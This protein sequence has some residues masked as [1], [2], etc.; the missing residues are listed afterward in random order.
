MRALV[1]LLSVLLLSACASTQAAN[2]AA[3]EPPMREQFAKSLHA[4]FADAEVALTRFDNA[5][6]L[7][8]L[9]EVEVATKDWKKTSPAE[10]VALGWLAEKAREIRF[11]AT[12]FGEENQPD[13]LKELF[14]ADSDRQFER[15]VGDGTT[16][17]SPACYQ[18]YAISGRN[19]EA[20]RGYGRVLALLDGRQ[21]DVRRFRLMVL[22]ASTLAGMNQIE[23]ADAEHHRLTLLLGEM[24]LARVQDLREFASY[25]ILPALML[26]RR[27][28]Y[29]EASKLMS[30]WF[31][32]VPEHLAKPRQDKTG[33]ALKELAET[34]AAEKERWSKE[35]ADLPRVE[36][37]TDKGKMVLT[38]FE[39]DC[40]NTVAS[41]ITLVEKGFYDGTLFHRVVPHFVVQGG[42]PDG[43]GSGGPGYAIKREATRLHF[44]GSIGMA[45]NADPDSAGS[46]FYFC[47]NAATTF[48]LNA[49]YCVFGRVSEGLDVM[50]QLRLGSRIIKARVLSKRA[51]E[52]KIER[53]PEKE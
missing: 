37:E 31:K 44:R 41:F 51:H 26:A 10:N 9:N 40:P 4:R 22:H 8:I 50:D 52:Y 5:G 45:R 1:L 23:Q 16:L 19:E 18:L 15:F 29:A 33:K 24:G 6:A 14:A 35:P 47:L 36:I 34:W 28:D 27:E 20:E 13:K 49:G 43:T 42:D 17:Q 25:C 12:I 46:Q 48:H 11:I 3:P 2:Q 38:L 30:D 7:K 53:L 39:D 32:E 21:N